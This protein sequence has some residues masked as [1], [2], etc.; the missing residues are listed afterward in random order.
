MLKYIQSENNTKIKQWRKLLTKKE[1]DRTNLFLVEGFHLVEEALKE[2]NRIVDIIIS[3]GVTF[4]DNWSVAPKSITVV[5]EEVMKRLSDTRTPQGII[6]VCRQNMEQTEIADGKSFVFIDA[7][8]DP[9]NVGTIIRTADAAGVDGVIVGEGS[10]DIYQPKVVR[11]AQGSHFHLPILRGNLSDWIDRMAK[12]GIPIYGTALEGGISF[13]KVTETDGYV[14]IVGNE[15]SGVGRE[16]LAKSD[17]NLY[18]PI[19]GKSESLNVA[20]ATGILV[21]HL[22]SLIRK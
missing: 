4:P 22:Q 14:L 18:I 6:A 8:Q 13:T 20:V 17:A 11:A 21:Y 5:T 19:Y 1:R 15:G 10:A 3:E 9:G 7:V 2:R 16:L 12:R